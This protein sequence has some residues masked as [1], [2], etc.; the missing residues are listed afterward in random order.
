MADNQPFNPIQMFVD[1]GQSAVKGV[2]QFIGDRQVQAQNILTP[3]MSAVQQAPSY[4]MTEVERAMSPVQQTAPPPVPVAP[5][6]QLHELTPGVFLVP[7]SLSV[8]KPQT[9]SPFT[10]EVKQTEV[11]SN[12]TPF[13]LISNTVGGIINE[14]SPFIGVPTSLPTQ[15]GFAS[16][17]TEETISGLKAPFVAS[18]PPGYD[19]SRTLSY[20]N[21]RTDV[22]PS[23]YDN[24]N[25]RMASFIPQMSEPMKQDL[26]KSGY[27]GSA[28]LGGYQGVAENPLDIVKGVS[29]DIIVLAAFEALGTYALARSAGTVLQPVVNTV[30]KAAPYAFATVYTMGAEKE[31]TKNF[32][33]FSPMAA[34][35]AGKITTTEVIP[36]LA[37]AGFYS[38][39]TKAG[40]ALLNTGKWIDSKLPDIQQGRYI[41]T[42]IPGLSRFGVE[43][44]PVIRAGPQFSLKMEPLKNTL[45]PEQTR[46]RQKSMEAM[47]LPR[48][49]NEPTFSSPKYDALQKEVAI[50][51]AAW[52]AKKTALFS[53]GSSKNAPVVPKSYSLPSSYD[54]GGVRSGEIEIQRGGIER[55]KVLQK[56]EFEIRA[57]ER[58]SIRQENLKE[59]LAYEKQMEK[60]VVKESVMPESIRLKTLEVGKI[61]VFEVE[62]I[63]SKEKVKEKEREREKILEVEK[64]KEKEVEREREKVLEK[65][66]VKEKEKEREREKVMEVEKV[67]EKEKEREREKEV[68]KEK[69]KES[70]RGGEI[71]KIAGLPGIPLPLSLGG[72]SITTRTP[73]RGKRFT[74]YFGFDFDVAGASRQIGSVLKRGSNLTK[75]PKGS[76]FTI[77]MPAPIKRSATKKATTGGSF[78]PLPAPIKRSSG[79]KTAP[80]KSGGSFI[81]LPQ[82]MSV[83][84][85]KS[86]VPY[87]NIPGGSAPLKQRLPVKKPRRNTAGR[88]SGWTMNTNTRSL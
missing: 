80:I 84:S 49:Y 25:K 87:N 16:K 85:T 40:N 19:R 68:E 59:R 8:V 26:R 55:V 18:P 4:V 30:V 48:E 9:P 11:K 10:Y 67:K 31:I 73:V 71:V 66:K 76:G 88:G 41:K 35:R 72:G 22:E 37:T 64:V 7:G 14:F 2:T 79:S 60:S 65:E 52:D 78:I 27:I 3:V 20:T 74:E 61:K 77:P 57:A 50:K 23:V 13:N 32:T 1:A 54:R 70:E 63:L 34:E 17:T 58:E 75:A 36:F 29:K 44:T 81:P 12:P 5:V 24:I 38:N 15:Q 86:T 69:E 6:Q 33:D 45:T 43:G 39:P 28:I 53:T 21:I 56:S 51:Q 62:K 82:P 42:E 83:R 46:L 47:R